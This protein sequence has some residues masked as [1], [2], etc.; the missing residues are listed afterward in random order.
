MKPGMRDPSSFEKEGAE[1]V[2]PVRWE[3]LGEDVRELRG[4]ADVDELDLV[5]LD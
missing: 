3:R 4:A 5:V 2:E 1:R